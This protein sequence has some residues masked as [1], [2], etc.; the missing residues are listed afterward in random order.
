MGSALGAHPL[1]IIFALLAGEEIYGVPG[2]LLS[3][4]LIAM[5]REAYLFLRHRV[6]FERWPS[7]GGLAGAGLGVADPLEPDHVDAPLVTIPTA[8]PRA[9]DRDPG[10]DPD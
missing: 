7:Q 1:L 9:P 2:V 10:D 3:L 5:G 8:L 6:R 4:P